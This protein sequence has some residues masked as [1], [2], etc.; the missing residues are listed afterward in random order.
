MKKL[1]IFLLVF[2]VILALICGVAKAGEIHDA[3]G[4]GDLAAV[5]RLLEQGTNINETDKNGN[6]PLQVAAAKGHL[7]IVRF[8]TEY[9]A[10]T[11]AQSKTERK[12]DKQVEP[13]DDKT[14]VPKRFIDNRD[15]TGGQAAKTKQETGTVKSLEKVV[16]AS[17]SGTKIFEPKAIG[18][19]KEGVHVLIIEL[20]LINKTNMPVNFYWRDN[21]PLLRIGDKVFDSQGI[22]VPNWLPMSGGV[23]PYATETALPEK[24]RYMDGLLEILKETWCVWL[25]LDKPGSETGDHILVPIKNLSI[26]LPVNKIGKF[27]FLFNVPIGFSNG[28]LTLSGCNPE[29]ISIR[30][31]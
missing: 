6:T 11:N 4:K 22:A 20:V 31:P 2:V 18:Y 19:N 1:N 12:I 5:K 17:V 8:L 16:S 9:I 15:S 23:G 25:S 24:T 21:V 26:Q 14:V 29:S 7:E 30:M 13:K 10:N 27:K 28:T 3:A